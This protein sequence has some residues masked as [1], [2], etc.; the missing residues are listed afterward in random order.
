MNTE[1]YCDQQKYGAS[2]FKV[3]KRTAKSVT[4]VRVNGKATKQGTIPTD[5][6]MNGCEPMRRKIFNFSKNK[7]KSAE[8][9]E[10]DM[11]CDAHLWNGEAVTGYLSI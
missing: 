11:G 9:I 4:V 6:V 8:Y 1:Y 2:F 5:E 10:I 7:E 3:L